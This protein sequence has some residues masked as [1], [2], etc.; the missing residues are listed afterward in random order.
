MKERIRRLTFCNNQCRLNQAGVSCGRSIRDTK[1]SYHLVDE[2]HTAVSSSESDRVGVMMWGRDRLSAT[3]SRKKRSSRR[4]VDILQGKRQIWS[5]GKLDSRAHI[6]CILRRE[7]VHSHEADDGG[8]GSPC[9]GEDERCALWKR[10]H[11]RR[12]Q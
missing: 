7:L 1:A 4:E 12:C 3:T 11:D 2:W 5:E 9:S 10:R 6:I 8:L